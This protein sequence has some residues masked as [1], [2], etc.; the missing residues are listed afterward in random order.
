MKKN[1]KCD[2]CNEKDELSPYKSVCQKCGHDIE[3]DL[4]S[5]N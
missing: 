4:L 1:Q 3:A 2:L 5:E